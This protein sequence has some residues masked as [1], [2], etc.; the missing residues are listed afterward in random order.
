MNST[1]FYL[2]LSV[3]LI[4]FSCNNHDH[5]NARDRKYIKKQSIIVGN[6][7][8]DGPEKYMYY[9]AAVKYGND[10]LSQPSIHKQYKPGY[11]NIEF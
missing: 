3:L 6:Q 2:F 7:K 10:D 5:E 4:A 11:K 9:H 8:F 1:R